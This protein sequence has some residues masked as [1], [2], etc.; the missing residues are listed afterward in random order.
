[1]SIRL[2]SQNETNPIELSYVTEYHVDVETPKTSIA[3]SYETKNQMTIKLKVPKNEFKNENVQRLVNWGKSPV[4]DIKSYYRDLAVNIQ[5][6]GYERTVVFTDAKVTTKVTSVTKSDYVTINVTANQWESRLSGVWFGEDYETTYAEAVYRADNPITMNV[7]VPIVENADYAASSRL[8]QAAEYLASKVINI[9]VTPF[10]GYIPDNSEWKEHDKSSSQGWNEGRYVLAYEVTEDFALVQTA[11]IT[12]IGRKPGVIGFELSDEIVLNYLTKKGKYVHVFSYGGILTSPHMNYGVADVNLECTVKEAPNKSPGIGSSISNLFQESGTYTKH[13]GEVEF[14]EPFKPRVS[15]IRFRYETEQIS[16][17]DKM[18]WQRDYVLSEGDSVM[19]FLKKGG[20]KLIMEC[21][22]DKVE[23]IAVEAAA[24]TVA[25]P[26]GAV[27]ASLAFKIPDILE[28]FDNGVYEVNTSNRVKLWC[29][30]QWVRRWAQFRDR[31]VKD[32]K[33]ENLWRWGYGTESVYCQLSSSCSLYNYN[34]GAFDYSD[35]YSHV[36]LET[37]NNSKDVQHM[38]DIIVDI[39]RKGP[40]YSYD[41]ENMKMKVYKGVTDVEQLIY[42]K[43]LDAYKVSVSDKS[44]QGIMTSI[45]DEIDKITGEMV[46]S[47]DTDYVVPIQPDD[48]FINKPDISLDSEKTP[49]IMKK[50]MLTPITLK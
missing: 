40:Q 24:G 15:D 36:L 27:A 13:I 26:V 41:F 38:H 33:Q 39:W 7:I 21:V 2:I 44:G 11:K 6:E 10:D 29:R 25:G 1:M 16:K 23:E 12:I 18:I 8:E 43:K 42:D 9:K 31:H 14:L 34:T 20:A 46:F 32:Q 28:Q 5:I 30:L 35:N 45:R 48:M 49:P 22:K 47:H 4:Y 50:D 37:R 19:N 17:K 3:K